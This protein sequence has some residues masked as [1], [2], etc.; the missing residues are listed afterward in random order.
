MGNF[1][2]WIFAE[3]SFN[4]KPLALGEIRGPIWRSKDLLMMK[5]LTQ[6]CRKSWKLKI[7]LFGETANCGTGSQKVAHHFPAHFRLAKTPSIAIWGKIFLWGR[8][9]GFPPTVPALTK[10]ETL[11]FQDRFLR[12]SYFRFFAISSIYKIFS[13]NMLVRY[14]GINNKGVLDGPWTKWRVLRA[15]SSTL[16]FQF[17]VKCWKV[18][19]LMPCKTKSCQSST[20]YLRMVRALP[21]H[22]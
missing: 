22:P 6:E 14:R 9:F 15:I 11:T 8:I 19:F 16:K 10:D 21:G 1:P 3:G 5:G 7:S 17:T 18:D 13:K 2:K 20:E 12:F 4:Q